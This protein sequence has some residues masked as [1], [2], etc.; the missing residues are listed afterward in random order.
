MSQEFILLT[1]IHARNNRTKNVL[2]VS[3]WRM[4]GTQCF[5]GHLN[6]PF[7]FAVYIWN[8]NARIAVQSD[9]RFRCVLAVWKMNFPWQFV[10]MKTTSFRENPLIFIRLAFFNVKII[11]L[12]LNA[13]VW[14]GRRMQ[15]QT[16]PSRERTI[17]MLQL[18]QI[19]WACTRTA[20]DLWKKSQCNV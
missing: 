15:I 20:R 10:A 1:V 12:F 16:R 17:G 8:R 11:D 19:L 3:G 7:L 6:D 5:C 2:A 9:F 14:C 18:V 13:P 4:H